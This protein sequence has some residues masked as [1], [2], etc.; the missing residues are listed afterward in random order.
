MLEKNAPVARLLIVVATLIAGGAAI[1]TGDPPGVVSTII[2]PGAGFQDG[3]AASAL[4]SG[5]HGTKVGPDG[6]IYFVDYNNARIRQIAPDGTVSTI[7]GSGNKNVNTYF[8]VALDPSKGASGTLYFSDA[9]F[10]GENVMQLDLASGTTTLFAGGGGFGDPNEGPAIGATFGLPTGLAVGLNGDVY[11]ADELNGVVRRVDQLG[12]SIS[13]FAGNGVANVSF[14][15]P[16]VLAADAD[17]TIYISDENNGASIVYAV[18]GSNVAVPVAGGGS[19]A[20]GIGV[21]PTS[22]NLGQVE[23]LTTDGAGHVF[24]GST[25]QVF[26]LERATSSLTVFAGSGNFNDPETTDALTTGFAEITGLALRNGTV[27]ITDFAAN[28]IRAINPAPP[29]PPELIDLIDDPAITQIITNG[30]VVIVTINGQDFVVTSASTLT[31]AVTVSNDSH[32][33]IID[34]SALASVGGTIDI[35]SD[36]LLQTVNLGSLTTAGGIA[37]VNDPT[38][39]VVSL[40][41]LTSIGGDLRVIGTAITTLN[42]G[43]VGSIGGNID[44]N[45]N[46]SLTTVNLGGLG[47]V[48]GSVSISNNPSL[49][50][51]NLGALGTVGGSVDVSGNPG[52]TAV[53]LGGLT[54]AGGTITVTND[55]SATVIDL[56]SLSGGVTAVNIANNAIAG[57]IDLGSLIS[58]S[59]AINIGSN[60]QAGTIDLTALTSAGS[61]DISQNATAGTIDLGSVTT[62]PGAV[63]IVTTRPQASSTSAR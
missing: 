25:L 48:G 61:I 63:N 45:T 38:L 15:F 57:T 53:S 30:G 29:P 10:D 14:A 51:T 5:P 47:S 32:I 20:V 41:S 58:V 17:G 1:A 16:F 26:K 8:D 55:P 24:I 11:I 12:N 7:A 52:I 4:I 43:G 39:S 6:T 36:G 40:G 2:G 60:A 37:L 42:L 56:G 33:T 54:T 35:E 3:P 19:S 9:S 44:I 62:V 21:A 50:S 22:A 49:T 59:G 13:V 23:S 27:T 28:E 31:G 46:P 18:D 34:L